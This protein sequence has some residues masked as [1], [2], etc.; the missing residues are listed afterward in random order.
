M[1]IKE[2]IL[3]LLSIQIVTSQSIPIDDNDENNDDKSN[4]EIIF[5][6]AASINK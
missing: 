3:S 6:P 1:Q 5:A 4:R 2:I